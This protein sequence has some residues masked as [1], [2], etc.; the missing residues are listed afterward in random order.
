MTDE[1]DGRR[2]TTAD[3]FPLE[4][5]I[6]VERWDTVELLVQEPVGNRDDDAFTGHRW[7]RS[8]VVLTKSD[9]DTSGV[10]A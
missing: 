7:R 9:T 4:E 1:T 10:G 8:L 6:R 5:T 3:G 2:G